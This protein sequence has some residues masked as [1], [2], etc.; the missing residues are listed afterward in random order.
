[1]GYFPQG[2]L[3]MTFSKNALRDGKLIKHLALLVAALPAPGFA[4]LPQKDAE[5]MAKAQPTFVSINPS[6]GPDAN[7]MV[8]VAALPAGVAA[9]NALAAE[10]AAK[11]TTAGTEAPA[12]ETPVTFNVRTDIP[13]PPSK[14]GGGGA[15]RAS[16]YPFATMTVGASF[17]IPNGNKKGLASTISNANKKFKGTARF[18]ARDAVMG[19]NGE[20]EGNG[21]RV[22]CQAPKPVKAAPA[23]A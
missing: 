19:Q 9:S 21:V 7:G 5:E 15:G 12:S 11:A 23:T 10:K 20:V 22:F 2:D 13:L 6:V 4:L 1:L 18:V 14:Q 8:Q 16:K 3:K 17:L